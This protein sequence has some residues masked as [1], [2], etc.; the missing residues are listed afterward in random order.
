MCGTL[1]L[2]QE[3]DGRLDWPHKVLMH[4]WIS[5]ARVQWVMGASF[6]VLAK[7]KIGSEDPGLRSTPVM[8]DGWG[9]CVVTNT[10]L[11]DLIRVLKHAT[12]LIHQSLMEDVRVFASAPFLSQRISTIPLPTCRYTPFVLLL[13]LAPSCP[14]TAPAFLRHIFVFRR[15]KIAHICHTC[16]S[17]CT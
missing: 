1:W 14:H 5:F 10:G 16:E 3:S 11:F 2:D 12:E 9:C 17:Y 8:C 13:P 7:R 15:D 4:A 6:F